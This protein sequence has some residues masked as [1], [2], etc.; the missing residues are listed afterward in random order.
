MTGYEYLLVFISYILFAKVCGMIT[1]LVHKNIVVEV[2]SIT[3]I[4]ILGTG[5]LFLVEMLS[6]VIKEVM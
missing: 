2:I 6:G 4:A 1:K 5:I 3:L